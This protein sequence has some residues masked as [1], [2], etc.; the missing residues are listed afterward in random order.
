MISGPPT[1]WQRRPAVAALPA[2]IILLITLALYWPA[3]DAGFV[4]DDFMILHRLR[5]LSGSGG[6]LR[7]FGGEFFGYYRPLAFVSDAL[8]W[9]TAGPDPRQFHTTNLF[10]HG[11]SAVLVLLITR[12]LLLP[13]GTDSAPGERNSV[14]V[15]APAAAALLFALHASNHEAVVWVSARFDL[16]ATMWGLTAVWCL[17]SRARARWLP[18]LVFLPAVLSKESTVA[19]PIAA[20][21]WPVF[22]LRS[23][24]R[25]TILRVLPWLL[26]LG[27][28]AV[29]RQL[30]GGVPAGG[31]AARVPK[32]LAFAAVLL[33]LVVCA[34]ER[35][36]RIRNWLLAHSR[37]TAAFIV[38]A[39][40]ALAL[41]SATGGGLANIAQEKLAVSGFAVLYLLVPVSAV[42]TG[43]GY[44]EPL[45]SIYSRVAL[46]GLPAVALIVWMLRKHLIQ[47]D[48]IW[49]LAALLFATLLPISALTEGRRY[50]YL[51]SAV[52]AIILG[53]L[54]A[55]VRNRWRAPA[56]VALA[57]VLA[58]SSWRIR[59]ALQD[60]IWAG[61]MTADG[62]RLVDDALAPSCE[63]GHVV[64]LTS[65]VGVRGVYTH[66]Y[67]ETFE[68]PRG[69]TPESF[70][71][72]ARLLRV[73]SNVRAAW[74]GP[75][76]IIL[77]IPDYRGNLVLSE[78]LRRFDLSLR[79]VRTRVVHTPIGEVR[80]EPGG[81]D[82][83]LTLTLS[84]AS[85]R[86]S[87]L[88]FYF[89]AG[90]IHRLTM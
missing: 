38:A 22:C 32:L 84:S 55:Q 68:L 70:Q 65:P 40:V 3:R 88:F 76:Q 54:I 8:D 82:Q 75:D 72:V 43:A 12:A 57:A 73:D 56:V 15:I 74:A 77:T 31:G 30:A 62:A 29:A 44:I 45:E 53:T 85:R 48:R 5:D 63:S 24:T 9:W 47:D 4:G 89:S 33:F 39:G 60:W 36:L 86:S 1:S 52:V 19:L 66:F 87:T 28:Y 26:V 90:A 18:A 41:L 71:V 21:A 17:V 27:A 37:L 23:T 34:D 64:F 25:E 79:E 42:G 14:A 59:Q 2:A 6:V 16:L 7:F 51:P 83:R 35:W 20:A 11:L 67:Y 58:V 78:D 50:L 13:A 69:C 10:M 46:M 61:K 49:F 81:L 80:A